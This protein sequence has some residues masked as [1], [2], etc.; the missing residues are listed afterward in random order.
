MS[1]SSGA[2]Y[3]IT[4]PVQEGIAVWPGDTKYAF[5]LGWS[6]AKGD[7]VN[8]GTVTMSVHTGTHADAPFH[9][10]NEGI[11]IGEVDINAFLG[12]AIVVDV[13]G[14]NPIPWES[15]AEIDFT[16]TPRILL[17]TGAW[18]NH[19]RFPDAVPTLAPDV[20]ARLGHAGVVLL[21]VDIPS[22]DELDSKEL[23]IHHALK[24]A[25]ISILESID[26]RAIS[27]RIYHLTALPLR[28]MGADGS[29]VRAI[30]RAL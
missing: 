7:A 13:T 9:F 12:A 22:V 4:I 19:S 23:P 8:V 10:D 29:P 1:N 3:D 24:T 6:T 18:T 25:G 17:K 14:I 28:L 30:L 2:I 11:G 26:L 21:G 27:P 5:H 15:L 16:A 20:P